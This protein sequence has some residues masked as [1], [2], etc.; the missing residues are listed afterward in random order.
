MHLVIVNCHTQH[1]LII[2][3]ISHKI[4]TTHA[5]HLQL[6]KDYYRLPFCRPTGGPKMASENLGEFLTG[7]KIQN[8]A[9]SI[10]MLREVYCQVLCQVTLSEVDAH[11]L[12]MHIKH[13]YHNNWIIDNLPSASMGL[14]ESGHHQMHYAGDSPLDSSRRKREI[15]LSIT[16]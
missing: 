4:K 13:G 11:T 10:N 2:S 14:T 8:S 6:P 7:N 9:Y 1:V 16:T 15:P 5:Q 12:A 3:Y